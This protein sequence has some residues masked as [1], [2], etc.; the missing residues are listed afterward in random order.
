MEGYLSTAQNLQNYETT[1]TLEEQ[2]LKGSS[3]YGNSLTT[4][5]VLLTSILGSEG[6]QLYFLGFPNMVEY[7]PT[8]QS[9][10]LTRE[11]IESDLISGKGLQFAQFVGYSYPWTNY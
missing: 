4:F 6:S 2:L 5:S 10:F 7:L 1:K 8:T 3:I 11:V 9:R